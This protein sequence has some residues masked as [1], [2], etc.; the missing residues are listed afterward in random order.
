MFRIKSRPRRASFDIVIAKIIRH[1]DRIRMSIKPR[2]GFLTEI[3]PV[4]TIVI[5]S[6]GTLDMIIITNI[7]RVSFG[8]LVL[9]TVLI[10]RKITYWNI[11]RNIWKPDKLVLWHNQLIVFIGVVI[12]KINDISDLGG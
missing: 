8:R 5:I 4:H 2:G 12:V 6:D 11:P 7:Y 1:I 3:N 9:P 10:M